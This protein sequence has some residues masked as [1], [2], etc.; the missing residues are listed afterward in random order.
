[1]L[2]E[3]KEKLEREKAVLEANRAK[4][5]AERERELAEA[6]ERI[7]AEQRAAAQ[8]QERMDRDMRAAAAAAAASGRGSG[9]DEGPGSRAAGS[10]DDANVE[11]EALALLDMMDGDDA[12]HDDGA[13]KQ[14]AGQ[15]GHR[16]AR[17]DRVY[18][19]RVAAA[20]ARPCEHSTHAPRAQGRRCTEHS[21]RAYA[22]R[23]HVDE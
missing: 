6:E 8:R 23:G 9:R 12:S 15:P 11:A 4:L 18:E 20:A 16:G 14:Q 1:M 17:T 3:E 22:R 13:A 19:S 5:E 2:A 10:A 21:V 7:D